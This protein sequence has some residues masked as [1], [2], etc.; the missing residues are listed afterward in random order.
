MLCGSIRHL[1]NY[2]TFARVCFAEKFYLKRA[3]MS[4]LANIAATQSALEAGT[5]PR[6]SLMF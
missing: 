4:L 2:L 6:C 5:K 1:T 3:G